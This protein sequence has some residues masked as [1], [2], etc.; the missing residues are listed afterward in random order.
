MTDEH[1]R[2]LLPGLAVDVVRRKAE[3]EP[4]WVQQHRSETD[5]A[6]MITDAALLDSKAEEDR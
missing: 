6:I 5:L 3:A 2:E 1:L 4:S